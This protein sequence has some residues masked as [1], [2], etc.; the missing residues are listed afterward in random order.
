MQG[1]SLWPLL[2]GASARHDHRDDVYCEYYNAM[3][4]HKSPTAQTTMIRTADWKL[5]V[6]HARDTG[7]LYNLV[8]DPQ[9]STNLWH[10][11]SYG[12]R[13]TEMLTRLCHRMAWT[14]DPLPERTAPW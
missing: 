8:S 3:P 14:V 10:D 9:E 7:E 12:V 13:K 6:D 5:T 4:W 2:T 11:P 1:Q